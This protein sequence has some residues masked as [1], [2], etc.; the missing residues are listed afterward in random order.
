MEIKLSGVGIEL[1]IGDLVYNRHRR[2]SEGNIRL[3]NTGVIISIQ[4]GCNGLI[5]V[6]MGRGYNVYMPPKDL[7]HIDTT[8]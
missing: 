4:S 3:G 8:D 1:K 5:E 6:N 7:R 2:D